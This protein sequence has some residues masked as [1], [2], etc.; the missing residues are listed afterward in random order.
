MN[1][2]GT[3]FA[4]AFVGIATLLANIA[5]LFLAFG[6]VATAKWIGFVASI[7]KLWGLAILGE[8]SCH[9]DASNGVS[10]IA[11]IGK[12]IGLTDGL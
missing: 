5:N 1:A 11:T 6:I 7:V 12:G 8:L 9:F 3:P 10:G 4:Y 2:G